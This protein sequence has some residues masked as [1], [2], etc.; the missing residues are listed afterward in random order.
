MSKAKLLTHFAAAILLSFSLGVYPTQRG[1]AETLLETRPVLSLDCVDADGKPSNNFDDSDRGISI[2][3]KF[4]RA[5]ARAYPGAKMTCELPVIEDPAWIPYELVLE[6]G[7]NDATT[8]VSPVRV[9]AYVDGSSSASQIVTLGELQTIT[10]PIR[11]ARSVSLEV[12][13]VN[14][15]A[16]NSWL[17]FTQAE[18]QYQYIQQTQ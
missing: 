15:I 8:R 3:R 5:I 9:T 13:C 4:Y 14:S 1:D 16:C 11:T 18:A 6:F 17:Y 12:E 7:F 2:G 10:V